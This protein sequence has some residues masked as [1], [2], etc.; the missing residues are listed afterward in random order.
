MSC[1]DR[2]G[3]A[4][5][6]RGPGWGWGP[7]KRG[8][9]GGVVVRLLRSKRPGIQVEASQVAPGASA[10]FVRAMRSELRRCLPRL[11][12]L[13]PGPRG[14]RRWAEGSPPPDRAECADEDAAVAQST[15]L[16]LRS[17]MCIPSPS[18]TCCR[19]RPLASGASAQA[20]HMAARFKQLKFLDGSGA[21]A[22]LVPHAS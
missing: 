13:S 17:R 15:F 1:N 10:P 16:R 12:P 3:R 5:G 4:G 18:S 14:K 21:P 19:A 8:G 6:R 7:W 11:D 20:K 2:P 9:A 22:G